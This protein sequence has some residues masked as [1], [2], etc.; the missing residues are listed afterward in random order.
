[1]AIN[2]ELSHDWHECVTDDAKAIGALMGIDIDRVYFSGFWSQGD[3]ACFEGSLAYR[4]GCVA[5]VKAYAPKDEEL[6]KI[7]ASWR[8][9]HKLAMYQAQ[10]TVRH[11]GHYY[12]EF[13]TSFDLERPHSISGYDVGLSAEC[14]EAITEAAR[15]FMRWIYGRLEAQYEYSYAW[16]AARQW[17]DAGDAMKE[18]RKAARALVADMRASIGKGME[19]PASICSA[20]RAQL[21]ALINDWEE[22]RKERDEL[23]GDFGYWQDGQR[24]TIEQFA[25]SHI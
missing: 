14:E 16:E 5:A 17:S 10:G 23:A 15:D 22:A 11:S 25:A 19:A 20:L 2:I 7:A 3:G 12:H 9:A 1:M 4:A 21:R 18:A 8:D 24:L 13:C 6:H